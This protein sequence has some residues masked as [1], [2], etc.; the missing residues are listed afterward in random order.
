MEQNNSGS[1]IN[2]SQLENK[3][4]TDSKINIES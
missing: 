2:Y 4:P 1:E 3:T